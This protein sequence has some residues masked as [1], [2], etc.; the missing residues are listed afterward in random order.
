MPAK[1]KKKQ[2]HEFSRIRSQ[3][4]LSGDCHDEELMPN[5]SLKKKRK[6]KKQEDPLF[7]EKHLETAPNSSNTPSTWQGQVT[8]F[9][10]TAMYKFWGWLPKPLRQE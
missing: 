8:H 5:N 7:F 10:C 2:L 9:A 4:N 1:K 3:L 6:H